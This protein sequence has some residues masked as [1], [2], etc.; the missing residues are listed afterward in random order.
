MHELRT[1]EIRWVNQ[2]YPANTKALKKIK[3]KSQQLNNQFIHSDDLVLFSNYNMSTRNIPS[4]PSPP[5]WKITKRNS[6]PPT[7]I[8]QKPQ[9]ET[10]NKVDN[11]ICQIENKKEGKV[12]KLEETKA[13]H[14]QS[15]SELNASGL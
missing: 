15:S 7:N 14:Q 8:D 6:K 12:K 9:T 2:D 11:S 1:K 13:T 4:T 3:T 5:N 10:R